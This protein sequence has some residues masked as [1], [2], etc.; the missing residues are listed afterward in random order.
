MKTNKNQNFQQD[1]KKYAFLLNTE[2]LKILDDKYKGED[3]ENY[4]D[5]KSNLTKFLEN[6][7]NDE[8]DYC[9]Q[10][11]LIISNLDY[12]NNIQNDIATPFIGEFNKDIYINIPISLSDTNLFFHYL[13]VK[14]F[15]YLGNVFGNYKNELK[16]FCKVLYTKIKSLDNATPK[17]LN[18]LLVEILCM[19]CIFC[20]HDNKKTQVID[21]Y[22]NNHD[23]IEGYY[24]SIIFFSKIKKILYDYFIMIANSNCLETALLK[25]RQNVNF[26]A[27]KPAELNIKKS[28][29]NLFKKTFF[30]PFFSEESWG[31]TI[32]AFNLSFINID[33]DFLENNN[34]YDDILF[35]F[36]FIKYIISFLLLPLGNIFKI[37]ESHDE[38]LE[39]PKSKDKIS[40][41]GGFLMEIHLIN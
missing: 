14:F 18:N 39:T 15:Y 7:I 4:K 6:V 8:F 12:R 28:V 30:L 20:L 3:F 31:L 38:K 23:I 9:E 26:N 32:P 13:R 34:S 22:A 16:K 11:D 10:P 5:E 19:I 33:I 35:L 27:N 1:L 41:E 25:Y 2:K 37:Y 36:Y 29:D 40:Q 24:H 21:Y 17:L